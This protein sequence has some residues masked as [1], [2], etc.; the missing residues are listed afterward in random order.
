MGGVLMV[1]LSV[2]GASQRR[3]FWG[4]GRGRVV[5]S[6][7]LHLVLV[8]TRLV[9]RQRAGRWCGAT[10]TSLVQGLCGGA[11]AHT[12]CSTGSQR[13]ESCEAV[14]L[15][16]VEGAINPAGSMPMCSSIEMPR[17]GVLPALLEAALREAERSDA[18]LNLSYDWLPRGSRHGCV[19]RCFI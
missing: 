3:R 2:I 18:V 4:A 11:S 5:S 17:H 14:T 7:P 12:G 1:L 19:F 6:C 9:P 13:P 10:C 8:S 16:E 15:V